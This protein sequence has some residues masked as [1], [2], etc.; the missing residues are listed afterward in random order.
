MPRA[1]LLW[2]LVLAGAFCAVMALLPRLALERENRSLDL[3]V[4]YYAVRDFCQSEGLDPSPTLM[5]LKQAGVTSAAVSEMSL[6]RLVDEGRITVLSGA[7]L[8]RLMRKGEAGLPRSDRPPSTSCTYLLVHD[9]ST[10]ADL[11]T[12]LPVL[13]GAGRARQWPLT[14]AP[15]TPTEKKPAVI[16]IS[17]NLRTLAAGGLG[18]STDDIDR[19]RKVGL[20]VWLR[21]QNR[22]RFQGADVTAFFDTIGALSPVRGLIFEGMS[23]E[24][25][26]YPESLPATE[27]ALRKHELLFGNIEVPTVEAAQK[28]S[29]TLG[30]AL[31]DRTVR[32]FSIVALQQAKM[33]PDEAIDRYMLGAR[34]RN[35]RVLYLRLFA[36]P[37]PGATLLDT[38]LSY[39][40][41][42]RDALAAA[43]FTFDGAKPFRDISPRPLWMLGMTAGAAA[44]GVL[45]LELFVAVP[46]M[47]FAAIVGGLPLL[48]AASLT[49]GKGALVSTGMALEAA[50]VFSV[51]GLAFGLPML[52][53]ES[54]N[55]PSAWRA[56]VAALLPLALVTAISL[57]GGL[58]MAA[59]MAD[60]SFMLSVLQFRGI[61]LIMVAGPA[62]VVLYYITRIATP[63]ETIAELLE[64]RVVFWHIAAFAVL[65]AAAA[66]YIA[67]TGNAAPGAAS[68]YERAFRGFLENTL[69]VRPRFKEFA[70]AHPAWFVMAMLLWKRRGQA[71]MW[72]L[73]LCVAIGQV[74]V[75]DTFAHAHTP[76]LISLTRAIIGL[77]LGSVLGMAAGTILGVFVV[78][79]IDDGSGGLPGDAASAHDA[80]P[81]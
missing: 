55:A 32:V 33:T 65:A 81:S 20:Q 22:A 78:E 53:V 6:D 41:S 73:T 34:E 27:E 59:F 17:T 56:M 10:L 43:G 14:A 12:S 79:G 39:V 76:Y 75:V 54:Q 46:T 71:W 52:T 23:N 62:I 49:L 58:Y 21:P 63:R 8:A 77:L 7:E 74:D 1:R 57:V 72:L 29:Q 26:G 67:R 2:S 50:L 51:L 19:L 35:M 30:R 36:A 28:G 5:L 4:D 38:N 44:A 48:A 15:T 24:V 16:E 18:F 69:V 61:K 80:H 66:F 70:L 40:R 3:L 68:D 64:R 45:F 9:A 60:T 31:D 11:R 25:V 13:L 47:L 42:L 37:E